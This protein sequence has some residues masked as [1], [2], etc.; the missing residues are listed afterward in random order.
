M[1]LVRLPGSDIPR[2]LTFY[3]AMEEYVAR[4]MP[5]G[6]D[7][8]FTWQSDPTVIAGRNQLMEA[9][10]DTG[11]CRANG[12]ALVRRKSGGGCVYS[13]MG[14][15]MMSCVTDGGQVGFIFDRYLRRVALALSKRGIAAQVTGRNDIT[16]GGRKVSGNAFLMLPEGRC[17]IHGTLLCET[18][19]QMME[20][21]LTPTAAK[22]KSKGV[23]SVRSRVVNLK[24]IT[25]LGVAEMRRWMEQEMCDSETVLRQDDVEL[26]NEIEKTYIDPCF[27][28]G[29]NPPFTVTRSVMS[30]GGE[31]CI[32]ADVRNG[33]IKN[34]A[35]TGDFLAAGN[36]AEVVNNALSGHRFI[37]EEALQ[38][39][40]DVDMERYITG[41]T[42][43]KMIKIL[44]KP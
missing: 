19:L 26:I 6:R 2:R 43:E 3:L 5:S 27:V 13:D 24:E 22:L 32:K 4:E 23:A 35:L 9:E 33:I 28:N 38:A 25:G 21:A 39:L 44:F 30:S 11:Y 37:E 8:F 36:P 17:I 20:R 16:V 29:K 41:L 31:V 10:A 12:I 15:L 14:N 18:D 34:V 42:A 40:K 1:E 7:Y